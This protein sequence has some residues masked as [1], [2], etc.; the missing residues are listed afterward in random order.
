MYLYFNKKYLWVYSF[1][2]NIKSKTPIDPKLTLNF[3]WCL[4]WKSGWDSDV[5]SAV[6]NLKDILDLDNNPRFH[7]RTC[8]HCDLSEMRDTTEATTTGRWE[9]QNQ[10]P[11]RTILLESHLSVNVQEDDNSLEQELLEQSTDDE[12]CEHDDRETC[13]EQVCDLCRRI[14]HPR[15]HIPASEG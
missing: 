13:D 15:E 10:M 12:S 9:G 6:G 3:S 7:V 2:P 1:V 5:K 11:S 8:I 14:F 4:S